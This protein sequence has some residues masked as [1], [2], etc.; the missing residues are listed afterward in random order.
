[1]RITRKDGSVIDISPTRVKEFIPNT[2]PKAPPGSIQGTQFQNAQPNTK[3]LK[4]D[5]TPDEKKILDNLR[6]RK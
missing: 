4:R 1:M 6:I 5:P 2:H 3:G